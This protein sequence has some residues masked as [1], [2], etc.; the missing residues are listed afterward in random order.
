MTRHQVASYECMHIKEV[1]LEFHNCYK[2]SLFKSQPLQNNVQ[3]SNAQGKL[4]E[5]DTLSGIESKKLYDQG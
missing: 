3:N 1:A 5:K 4:W 2:V